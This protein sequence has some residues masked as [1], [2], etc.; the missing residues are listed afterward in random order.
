MT[1]SSAVSVPIASLP[2]E[3]SSTRTGPEQRL[4]AQRRRSAPKITGR[5]LRLP[6]KFVITDV[7]DASQ[8]PEHSEDDNNSNNNEYSSEDLAV[9]SL[10]A[11][12]GKT[13]VKG[14][15][16]ITDLSPEL[17]DASSEREDLSSSLGPTCA[18]GVPRRQSSRRLLT[19]RP[20]QSAGDV[21]SSM[22]LTNLKSDLQ[23][24][25]LR[26]EEPIFASFQRPAQSSPSSHST[27]VASLG[28]YKS[29]QVTHHINN[30]QRTVNDYQLEFLEKE[31]YEMKSILETMVA[32]NTQWI[33]A[34]ASVGLVSARPRP[35]GVFEPP[36]SL[37]FEEKL[38]DVEKAYTELQ[39]KHE[40]V[41]IQSERLEVKNA[42]L[43]I[44][45]QQQTNRS[46]MLRS[47]LD[48][49]TQ[50][51]EKLIGESSEPILHDYNSDLYSIL[52][53]HSETHSPTAEEMA[54]GGEY[55]LYCNVRKSRRQ[56]GRDVDEECMSDTSTEGDST[57]KTPLS[58]EDNNRYLSD[59]EL[60]STDT[61]SSNN[62][63]GASALVSLFDD[64]C[65][66]LCQS[67]CLN[68]GSDDV[69][70][71]NLRDSLGV[72][73]SATNSG[74]DEYNIDNPVGTP[75]G[76]LNG[77]KSER[78][79]HSNS[80]VSI[81]YS[82]VSSNS[83]LAG[84]GLHLATMA[85]SKSCNVASAASTSLF[86][87]H[88]EPYPNAL[89]RRTIEQDD[90]TIYNVLSP[91]NLRFHDC[92]SLI[93]AAEERVAQNLTSRRSFPFLTSKKATSLPGTKEVSEQTRSTGGLFQRFAV[94]RR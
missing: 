21:R 33:E 10:T 29:N 64:Q 5:K 71:L 18:R 74:D 81:N 75:K 48:K 67:S 43:E 77:Q 42:M 62:R 55:G 32:T 6:R 83:S 20:F 25:T 86:G 41:C 30:P 28:N 31:T 39:A 49:L 70:V 90:K 91:E 56:R 66:Q 87:P 53:K 59:T 3:S 14:R 15:F 7:P 24:S 37:P 2:L 13:Q 22:G 93:Q 94:R 47:Q 44:R 16:T 73:Q 76:L 40:T 45:L 68:Y 65:S 4:D 58:D 26:Q 11:R 92:Q 85:Q 36:A 23:Q 51:T 78:L 80:V 50:Y 52:G 17:S 54:S 88:P 63:D 61:T 38:R 84:Y 79:M 60:P 8:Q 72:C 69:S 46:A 9:S 82:T 27:C 35:N 12:K 57:R 89:N 1:T 34:L 19:R